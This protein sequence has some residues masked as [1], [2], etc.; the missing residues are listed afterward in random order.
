ML[1]RSLATSVGGVEAGE[2]TQQSGHN[3]DD[4]ST[5][6]DVLGSLLQDEES[7]LGVDTITTPNLSVFNQP[8]THIEAK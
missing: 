4:L 1:N 8:F 3:R 6:R 2:G 5:V 7:S